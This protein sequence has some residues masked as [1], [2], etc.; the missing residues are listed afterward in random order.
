VSVLKINLHQIKH[1]IRHFLFARRKGHGIHS[2]F[3]Y[4]LCEEVFY[5]HDSFYDFDSLKKIRNQL[6]ADK[7]KI[8]ITDFGAGSK[9]F[10]TNQRKVKDIADRGVSTTLQSE[11]FYKLINFL[12]CT[13]NIELGT[14]IGLNTLYLAQANKNGKLISIEGS[15][16]LS[17]FA[18][19]LAK[20]NN[21]TNIEFIAST[22][23]EALPRV[24]NSIPT[25]DFLYIDGNHR[26]AATIQYFTQALQKVHNNSVIVLDDIYWSSGM[27]KAWN[28]IKQHSRVTLTIDVFYFG[29][30]FFK[31]EIIEKKDIN[32][33]I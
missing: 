4:Q 11:L 31:K 27:T 6:L 10:R 14:S 13:N 30:V 2:P 28:E 23:E 16:Q 25:L 9:T 5:N 17:A 22:F 21:I 33:F 29:M 20:K 18:S 24:L 8:E 7:Q 32:L 3:A 26:Y 15:N 1:F 19:L 12:N